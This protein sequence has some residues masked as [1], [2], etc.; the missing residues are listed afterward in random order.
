[1][2][3]SPLKTKMENAA[4]AVP[5]PKKFAQT[6]RNR[7]APQMRQKLAS[8]PPSRVAVRCPQM[9]DT[10]NNSVV[11]SAANMTDSDGKDWT[12]RFSRCRGETRNE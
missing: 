8:T 7:N 2:P 10:A 4:P 6:A 9:A 12:R 1:M 11:R 3:A 5:V